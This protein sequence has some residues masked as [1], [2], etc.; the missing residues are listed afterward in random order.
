[1][2]GKRD[3][4]AIENGS[5]DPQAVGRHRSSGSDPQPILDCKREGLFFISIRNNHNKPFIPSTKNYFGGIQVRKVL[6]DGGCTSFLL[7]LEENQLEIVFNTFSSDSHFIEIKWSKN[8]GGKS[9]VLVITKQDGS[10]FPVKLCQDII[11]NDATIHVPF[12]RFHLCSE[13]VCT[14]LDSLSFVNRLT[15]SRQGI[16]NLTDDSDAH[17]GRGRK[18]HALLGQ[19]IMKQFASMRSSKIEFFVN[20][21]IYQIS[22]WEE[23]ERQTILIRSLL[24]LPDDFEDWEDDDNVGLDSGED[25][26]CDD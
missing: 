20:R 18:S 7:P 1:M 8:V 19:S 22:S 11:N 21:A 13:D 3:Y 15:S 12:L 2:L 24:K 17:N 23:I 26:E 14:I 4:S 5:E 6:C 9:P 16:Q 10:S 25:Y